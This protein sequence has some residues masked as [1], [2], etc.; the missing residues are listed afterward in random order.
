[1]RKIKIFLKYNIKNSYLN[2]LRITCLFN[3]EH[4]LYLLPHPF[5]LLPLL[6]IPLE[7]LFE[8]PLLAV[9]V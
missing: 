5:N 2:T 6:L 9:D 3:P 7:Y 8:L 1:M 4:D